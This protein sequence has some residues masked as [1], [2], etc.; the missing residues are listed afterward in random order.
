MN[1]K[2]IF[3]LTIVLLACAGAQADDADAS[4]HGIAFQSVRPRAEVRAEAARV[5]A[6]R[7][8]TPEAARP[9]G[10]VNSAKARADVRAEAAAAVRL[11]LISH[12]EIGG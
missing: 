11:G 3:T 2:H 10:F 7:D 8:H 9:Y 5:S 4:Q 1:R 12:G 6:T